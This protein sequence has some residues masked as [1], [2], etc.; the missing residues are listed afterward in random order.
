MLSIDFLLLESLLPA[1]CID[2][3]VRSLI[4]YICESLTH[5]QCNRIECDDVSFLAYPLR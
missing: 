1:L 2:R 3:N 4:L 5:T